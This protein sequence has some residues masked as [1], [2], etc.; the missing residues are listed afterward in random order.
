[1]KTITYII[2]CTLTLLGGLAAP[3][4]ATERRNSDFVDIVKDSVP[5]IVTL[6]YNKGEI[7]LSMGSGFLISNWGIVMT[8]KHVASAMI[9]GEKDAK[10][11]SWCIFTFENGGK[12]E[13]HC[14]KID[15]ESIECDEQQDVAFFFIPNTWYELP[16]PLCF[17]QKEP[18][19]GDEIVAIGFPGNSDSSVKISLL[20]ELVLF[21]ELQR[22][23][24]IK[25]NG[26]KKE[27]DYVKVNE[28]ILL[29]RMDKKK[30]S[31]KD[32]RALLDFSHTVQP[33]QIT[34]M[35][36]QYSGKI[37]RV[38]QH[39]ATIAQGNSGGPLIDRT[40]GFVVG[41]NT[42]GQSENV[43]LVIGADGGKKVIRSGQSTNCALSHVECRQFLKKK[44]IP[45][46]EGDPYRYLDTAN[47]MRHLLGF[48]TDRNPK[49]AFEILQ[50]TANN[51]DSDAY[52]QFLLGM[53]YIFGKKDN[54]NKDELISLNYGF[55]C[56]RNIGAAMEY[57]SRAAE[58]GM[59]DAQFL[60]GVNYID[61]A[62]KKSDENGILTGKAWLKRAAAQGH[63]AAKEFL[64]EFCESGK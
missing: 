41:I 28:K 36:E 52:S 11:A 4:S 25:A 26:V 22:N 5:R 17:C 39:S 58:R 35:R 3:L 63:P 46:F 54:N 13:F 6:I 29:E 37:G 34:T 33:G 19:V 12:K 32:C 40:T 48:S 15:P 64:E 10:I 55:G 44:G 61:E 1:M 38:I 45:I 16:A 21:I 9:G 51:K 53:S 8:N 27:Q 42:F 2:L 47:A 49:Y 31:S 43:E 7:G 57:L 56:D 23:E 50:K 14:Y 59:P 62:F 20:V 60:L 24:L 30:W 18:R